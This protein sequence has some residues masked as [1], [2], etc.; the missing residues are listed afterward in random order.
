MIA[1]FVVTLGDMVGLAFI[2]TFLIAYG[3]Y[4]VCMCIEDWSNR[5]QIRKQRERVMK[6]RDGK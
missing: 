2:G 1:L 4:G 5:R 3:I 6:A